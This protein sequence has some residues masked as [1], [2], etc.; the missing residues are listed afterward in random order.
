MAGHVFVVQGRVEA[1]V[2]DAVVV[3][4]DPQ[5]RI[6]P[7]WAPVLGREDV[8]RLRPEGWGRDGRSFGR[9]SGRDDLWFLDVTSATGSADRL[10]KGLGGVLDAIAESGLRASAGRALPLVAVPVP[11][12]GGGGFR[13]HSGTVIDGL[14]RTLGEVVL[15]HD[16]DIVVVATTQAQFAAI[17]RERRGSGHEDL[18]DALL[19]K[20]RALGEAAASGRVALF[21]GA[22]VSIPAGL[23]S[24]SQL[25]EEMRARAVE[26]GA[27]IP[28]PDFDALDVLDQTELLRSL[29]GEELEVRVAE[30]FQSASPAL[31]H[32]LLASL[33]CQEAVTTNYDC[34]YEVAMSAVGGADTS[35]VGGADTSVAVMPWE[36]PVPGRPWLL[37]LHGDAGRP[38]SVVLTR[39]QFI[40]YDGRWRPVGSVFQALLMTRQLLV[41]GASLSDDNVLRLAHEVRALRRRHDIDDPL[42][43]VLALGTPPLRARLW[44]GELDWVGFSGGSGE[45]QARH[46]EIFLD[47]VA[48][49]AS[50]ASPYLLHPYYA[51][52][53]D[54]VEAD[55]AH[56]ARELAADVEAAAAERTLR[57]DAGWDQLL[58]ALRSLGA[59]HGA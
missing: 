30:R 43:T 39:G 4:T 11:G 10:L 2:R 5:L 32:A 54:D 45:Q 46:L 21:L 22:G 44:E 36:K 47:A 52:L 38:E 8:A 58:G 49:Y 53:L 18:D 34:C 29:L 33:R 48:M 19:A 42:G 23:P 40:G 25:V 50:R 26:G 35:A 41:V 56:R 28:A 24:W 15:R 59:G 3:T 12:I 14:L 7:H 9:A 1:L 51:D 55:L 13:E 37:K 31:S 57:H 20:A 27:E 6:E 17:Q 16:V